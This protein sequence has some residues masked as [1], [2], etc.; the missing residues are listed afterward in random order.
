M[1]LIRLIIDARALGGCWR[2]ARDDADT[3]LPLLMPARYVDIAADADA[4]AR[5]DMMPRVILRGVTHTV[6]LAEKS[7]Q[8]A[9]YTIYER[10]EYA[11]CGASYA[12][13]QYFSLPPLRHIR[14]AM[15]R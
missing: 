6:L 3:P 4:R 15:L 9:Q 5:D 12:I 14:H 13:T 1:A 11:L 7:S 10:A 8:D 2:G